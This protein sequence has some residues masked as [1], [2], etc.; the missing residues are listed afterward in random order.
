MRTAALKI[1]FDDEG[2]LTVGEHNE[3]YTV[4]MPT[5]YLRGMYVCR[6]PPPSPRRGAAQG[7]GQV[8]LV[9]PY[10]GLRVWPAGRAWG[11]RAPPNPTPSL[12]GKS[13]IDMNGDLVITC[14]QTGTKA[15][16]TFKPKVTVPHACGTS[17]PCALMSW[18]LMPF[19]HSQWP[20]LCP[21]R[22]AQPWFFGEYRKV[23]G[24]IQDKDGSV[25]YRLAGKWADVVT[26]TDVKAKVRLSVR[27]TSAPKAGAPYPRELI[28]RL[29]RS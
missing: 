27:R 1:N 7:G 25:V 20:M 29:R 10:Q 9:S 2:T 3:A 14:A 15:V 28:Q 11:Q 5:W 8:A 4:R 18:R 24:E 13:F 19:P 26:I 21:A 23:E 17:A 16:I 22:P 6:A 12:F